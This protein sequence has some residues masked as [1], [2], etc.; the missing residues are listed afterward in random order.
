MQALSEPAGFGN[1]NHE[2]DLAFRNVGKGFHA[3]GAVMWL[4]GY[5]SAPQ[6]AKPPISD[7]GSLLLLATTAKGLCRVELHCR[8]IMLTLSGVIGEGNVR[9]FGTVRS[10]ATSVC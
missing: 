9:G 6:I 2:Q 3:G 1:S 8:G 4:Q 7:T 10:T 5:G